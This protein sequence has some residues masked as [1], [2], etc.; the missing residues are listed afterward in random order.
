MDEIILPHVNIKNDEP[1]IYC[2]FKEGIELGFP[3]IIELVSSIESLHNKRPYLI[4]LDVSLIKNI[5]NEGKRIIKRYSHIPF[6]MG[7]ALFIRKYRYECAQNFVNSYNTK[8]PFRA[9]HSEQDAEE[10][11][12]SLSLD[13]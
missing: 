1:V 8:F 9:F 10:W 3:E 7:V 13:C 4:L 11:L 5:T 6:C 12:L 2:K